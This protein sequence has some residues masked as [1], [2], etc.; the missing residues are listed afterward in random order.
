MPEPGLT[1]GTGANRGNRDYFAPCPVRKPGLSLEPGLLR[2]VP[3]EETGAIAGAGTTSPRPGTGTTSLEP[4]NPHPAMRLRSALTIT[5]PASRKQTCRL[6]S[7]VSGAGRNRARAS[8]AERAWDW[9]SPSSWSRGRRDGSPPGAFPAVVCR[10]AFLSGPRAEATGY[11]REGRA[12]TTKAQRHYPQ[13]S[14][15][16]DIPMRG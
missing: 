3:R 9:Q 16:D 14:L 15:E 4:G 13:S 1:A 12:L 10:C 2:P 5:A 6:F 8:R 11:S 7:T